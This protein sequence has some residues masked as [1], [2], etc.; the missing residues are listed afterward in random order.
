VANIECHRDAEHDTAHE[1]QPDPQ[2]RCQEDR[3]ACG[4]NRSFVG[5]APRHVVI[6]G[7]LPVLVKAQKRKQ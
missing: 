7:A 4:P 2:R 6:I 3:V 1:R 5:R